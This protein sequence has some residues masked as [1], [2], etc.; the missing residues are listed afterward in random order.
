MSAILEMAAPLAAGNSVTSPPIAPAAYLHF[1]RIPVRIAGLIVGVALIPVI[2]CLIVAVRLTSPG[3]GL[4]RQRRVGFRGNEFTIYKLRSMRQD[5]EALCGPIWAGKN[6][7]RVTPIGNFLRWS[8]LDEL[9]QILNVIRGEM[10]FVGPRPERPEIIEELVGLIEN[11]NDR[12]ESL[13]GITGIAQVNLPPDQELACVRKKVAADRYYIENASLWFDL[14]LI[15][16][17]LLRMVGIRYHHGAKLLGVELPAE[18]LQQAEGDSHPLPYGCHS[19]SA[20]D[21]K[22]NLTAYDTFIIE[23]S[24]PAKAAASTTS[25]QRRVPR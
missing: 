6:D 17:T 24:M 15:S 10:D 5:A 4:Y 14:R 18:I 8:H 2:L 23:D 21:T 3:P 19:N 12:H 7:S 11:Y 9:P 25:K 13:P 20:N 1:K 16:A 22:V